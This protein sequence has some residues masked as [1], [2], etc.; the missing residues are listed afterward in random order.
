LVH[1]GIETE[2]RKTPSKKNSELSEN[3]KEDHADLLIDLERSNSEI[4]TLI[5]DHIT[6]LKKKNDELMRSFQTD[7]DSLRQQI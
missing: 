1:K 2:P 7:I 5:M 4:N 6:D 3:N